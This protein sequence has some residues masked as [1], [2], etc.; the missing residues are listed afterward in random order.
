MI[1]LALCDPTSI[2]KLP[3]LIPALLNSLQSDITSPRPLTYLSPNVLELD[4]LYQSI[5]SASPEIAQLAWEYVNSLN[6][7]GDWRAKMEAFTNYPERNWI[8][9]EG[10]V[11]KMV[12]CLPYVGSFWLKASYRGLLHLR[13]STTPPFAER[14]PIFQQLPPPHAGYLSL[15]HYPAIPI[16]ENEIVSTTGAGDTLVG[17]IVAGLASGG[18]EKEWVGKALER[19]GRTMRSRRAVG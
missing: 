7:A 16:S 6:L 8:R 15:T 19:V 2:P 18:E 3:R 17:G 4:L 11:Q 9:N 5:S 14:D 10:V 1:A 13:I 12:A